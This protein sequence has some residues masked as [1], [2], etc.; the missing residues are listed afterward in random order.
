MTE[1]STRTIVRELAA[2]RRKA[3]EER[4]AYLL[5]VV[6]DH[7]ADGFGSAEIAA[8]LRISQSQAAELIGRVKK[9]GVR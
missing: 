6:A 2:E 8:R 1:P 3:R 9:G 5:R 7:L 4:R